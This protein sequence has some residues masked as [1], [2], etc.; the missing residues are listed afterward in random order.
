VSWAVEEK[1]Y[2]RR[3]ACALVGIAPRAYR[4]ISSWSDD[5]ALRA[6]VGTLIGVTAVRLP[7]PAPAFEA[8]GCLGELEEVLY[9]I[10]RQE[11]LTVR[12]EAGANGLWARE[13]RWPFRR[14]QTRD[15]HST[16]CRTRWST[17]VASASC[18]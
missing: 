3:R 17:A 7:P 8:G 6:F 11:R 16:S 4:Y 5:A 9:R 15:G 10:Y 18:A 13:R 14:I 2:S 12:D 1:S